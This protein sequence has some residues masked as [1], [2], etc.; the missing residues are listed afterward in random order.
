MFDCFSLVLAAGYGG[1]S[2]EIV[3]KRFSKVYGARVRACS[4]RPQIR[5]RPLVWEDARPRAR[6]CPQIGTL[7]VA[8]RKTKANNQKPKVCEPESPEKQMLRCVYV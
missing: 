6:N 8:D 1:L 2:Q 5:H 4:S 7:E 3:P